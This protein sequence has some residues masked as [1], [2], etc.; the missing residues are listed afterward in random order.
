MIFLVQC[1]FSKLGRSVTPSLLLVR[2]RLTF[3]KIV[4]PPFICWSVID[5]ASGLLCCLMCSCLYFIFRFVATASL[6]ATF[7][8]HSSTCPVWTRGVTVYRCLQ[9]KAFQYL[10]DCC[11]RTS[12]VSSHQ[13]FRSGNIH[14]L[15]VP[16]H[17][18]GTFGLQAFPLPV[19]WNGTRFQTLY[20][21]LLWVPKLQIIFKDSCLRSSKG[22]LKFETFAVSFLAFAVHFH[23]ILYCTIFYHTL[24]RWICSVIYCIMALYW[25]FLASNDV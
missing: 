18:H 9:N 19:R 1:F 15:M 25:F 10:I 23:V 12:D 14:Q 5:L 7:A 22:Q 21:T 2:F 3:K 20:R 24:L 11:M 16:R 4:C 13:C 17:R 8:G 6:K